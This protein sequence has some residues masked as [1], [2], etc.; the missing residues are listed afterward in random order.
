MHNC[1]NYCMGKRTSPQKTFIILLYFIFYRIHRSPAW[2]KAWRYGR[3]V[4]GEHPVRQGYLVYTQKGK[5]HV[6]LFPLNAC[7]GDHGDRGHPSWGHITGK[8]LN[9]TTAFMQSSPLVSVGPW[10]DWRPHYV[11]NDLSLV[12]FLFV[13]LAGVSIA[14]WI[15]PELQTCF[16]CKWLVGWLEQP[17][18]I[19]QL[20]SR[21]LLRCA[22]LA[23]GLV[24]SYD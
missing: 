20:S 9:I 14:Q 6:S 23:L 22:R 4:F 13:Q 3:T 11:C 19:I 18:P 1:G 7:L 8:N 21:K 12:N 17:P 15:S 5:G 24:H 16:W 10:T 2:G